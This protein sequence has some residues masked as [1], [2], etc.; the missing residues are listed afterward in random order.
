[1]YDRYDSSSRA[2]APRWTNQVRLLILVNAVVF[3]IQQFAGLEM[4]R[5]FG[6]TPTSVIHGFWFWQIV[7]YMFLHGDLFHILFNMLALWMFGSELEALWGGREFLKYY[8]LTGIGA[9]VTTLILSWNAATVTIGASGAV[10][11][12]LLAYALA[13]PDRIIYLYFLFPIRAKYLV[14]LFAVIEFILSFAY[15]TDGIGHFAHLGGMLFGFL[16][17]KTDWRAAQLLGNLRAGWEQYRQRSSRRKDEESAR[18]REQMD[19]ILD[20]VARQGMDSLSSR[21]R[22][23]LRR[24]SRFFREH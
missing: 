7:T 9:G 3:V 10:Y 21:E 11:G 18:L 19:S 12:L 24:A 17:L 13:F 22:A 4:L 5:V 6:L 8:F 2:Y 1:M 16:Y 20:K 14:A 15:T 23:L